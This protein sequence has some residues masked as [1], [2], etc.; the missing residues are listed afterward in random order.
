M[1]CRSWT[2]TLVLDDVEAEF[3]G[4]AEDDAGLDAA[5]GEPHREGVDVVVAADGVAVLAH[6]RAAE[7]AAPD[8][9]RVVEQAALLE[10]VHERGAGLVDFAADLL[11][12]V[13]EVVRRGRRGGPSWC[14]RAARS[15]RRARS[16]GGRAGS[17]VANDGLPGL[18]AVERRASPAF[19]CDR[20]ISSGALV[21]MRKAIS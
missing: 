1:A 6:R 13:V 2:W 8:D 11:E 18:D 15:A 16:A 17:C 10:V 21:C 5:A 9:Q 4:L 12:V 7:F 3:V 19:R 14:D 20:S